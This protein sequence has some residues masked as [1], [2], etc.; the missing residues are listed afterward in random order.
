MTP[1]LLPLERK[2]LL[3]AATTIGRPQIPTQATARP[4]GLA[5]RTLFTP[6]S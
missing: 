2:Q 4:A 5:E 1:L 6:G 3:E